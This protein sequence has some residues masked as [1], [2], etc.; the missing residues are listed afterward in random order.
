MYSGRAQTQWADYLGEYL[1]KDQHVIKQVLNH[2]NENPESGIYY[3]TSFWMMPDWVN[4]WLKN[5]PHAQKMAKEW[6]VELNDDFLT[7]PAGGMFW[8]RPEALEQL[9]SKDYN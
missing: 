3:P 8:A 2:F 5:K 1:L 7:Y 4:H 9:L 6:G